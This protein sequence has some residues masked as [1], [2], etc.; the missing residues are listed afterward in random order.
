ML[1]D[2]SIG[3]GPPQPAAAPAAP[4]RLLMLNQ[5][6][7]ATSIWD[8]QQR[9]EV[10]VSLL[11]GQSALSAYQVPTILA[12]QSSPTA[13]DDDLAYH[14]CLSCAV[15]SVLLLRLVATVPWLWQRSLPH[16]FAW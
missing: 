5:L 9:Q 11:I 10:C 15:Y 2:V 16:G 13:A 7:T 3:A 8:D 12:S 1:P 14:A 6:L 4:S